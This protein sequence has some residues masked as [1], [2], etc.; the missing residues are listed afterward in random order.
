MAPQTASG[1]QEG[2]RENSNERARAV[3]AYLDALS[4]YKPKRGRKRKPENIRVKMAQLERQLPTST[5]VSR[6]RVTQQLK[7]LE[8]ALAELE[9]AER[10]DLKSLEDQFVQHAKAF[11]QHEG[12]EYA[13]WVACG[14]PRTILARAGIF[15]PGGRMPG[16]HYADRRLPP[17]APPG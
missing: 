4:K 11:A 10:L 17:T 2:Q 5:G 3:G 9:N 15:P 1:Y 12:I 13:T 6:V 16:S 8:R 14:V 7:D